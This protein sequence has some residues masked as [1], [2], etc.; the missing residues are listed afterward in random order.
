[1]PEWLF[2]GGIFGYIDFVMMYLLGKRR[3]LECD[4]N[5]ARL[6]V[7]QEV[8]TSELSLCMRDELITR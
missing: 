4:T 3:R 6:D 1:M 2:W 8:V 7:F 5:V